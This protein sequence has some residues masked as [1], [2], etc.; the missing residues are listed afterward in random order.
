MINY[1]FLAP[2]F[3]NTSSMLKSIPIQSITKLKRDIPLR[4][5]G[6]VSCLVPALKSLF[7]SEYI[8]GH[9]LRVDGGYTL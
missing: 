2:G 5:F 8:N 7:F 1:H 9:T 6:S 3:L 4:Q